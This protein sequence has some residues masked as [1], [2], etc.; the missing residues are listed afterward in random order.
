M[1]P[2]VQYEGLY[3]VFEASLPSPDGKTP[4]STADFSKTERASPYLQE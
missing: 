1:E 2:G 4:P 3:N